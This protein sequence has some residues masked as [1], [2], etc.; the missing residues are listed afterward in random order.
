MIDIS[1]EETFSLTDAAKRLPCR[2]K[3][4]RPN[5]A[6]LYRWAQQGVRGVRLETICVGAT[7]CTSMEAIQRF[8]DALTA[9]ADRPAAPPAPRITARRKREMAAAEKRLARAGI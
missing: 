4:K 6:T 5:V 3:G 1:L 8:C 2:R 9:K 7:R